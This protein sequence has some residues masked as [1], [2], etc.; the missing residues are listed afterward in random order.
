MASPEE[1]RVRDSQRLSEARG[2]RAANPD[3]VAPA[4]Q[5]P[6]PV[7][8]LEQNPAPTGE[9]AA[10]ALVTARVGVEA[11]ARFEAD[12]NLRALLPAANANV[13]SLENEVA[14]AQQLILQIRK[15]SEAAN[16]I[17]AQVA[18][19]VQAAEE[20][21][22]QKQGQLE[23]AK[24]ARYSCSSCQWRLSKFKTVV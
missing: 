3:Q 15:I 14:K 4:A 17:V 6:A 23:G 9:R 22:R 11:A 1:R 2:G 5:N 8:N 18:V 12:G 16:V 24:A 19:N 10:A 13:A 21:F 7:L 20:Q